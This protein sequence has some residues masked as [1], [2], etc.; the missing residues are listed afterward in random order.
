MDSMLT[1]DSVVHFE[2]N[3]FTFSISGQPLV[4]DYLS[5]DQ[6]FGP[7][8]EPHRIHLVRDLRRIRLVLDIDAWGYAAGTRHRARVQ[9]FVNVLNEHANDKDK[10]SCLR[11]LTVVIARD[12]EDYA[13]DEATENWHQAQKFRP[14]KK[15]MFALEPLVFLLEVK[16]FKVVSVPEWFAKCLAMCVQCKVGKVTGYRWPRKGVKGT[17]KKWHQPALDWIEFARRNGIDLPEGVDKLWERK[18]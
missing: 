13:Y 8:R 7:L 10:Q 2:D 5:S 1:T 9:H 17:T 6:I 12:G 11:R 14:V 3:E 15:Q 16:E 4:S 18:K